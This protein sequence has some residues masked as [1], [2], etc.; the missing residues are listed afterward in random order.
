MSHLESVLE[1]VPPVMLWLFLHL[2]PVVTQR[3]EIAPGAYD[4]RHLAPA[5]EFSGGTRNDKMAPGRLVMEA[6]IERL[7][8]A[9]I[10]LEIVSSKMQTCHCMTNGNANG[11]D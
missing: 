11:L 6:L 2:G 4:D 9:V 7:E 5:R 8:Q 1:S 3:T 10:R